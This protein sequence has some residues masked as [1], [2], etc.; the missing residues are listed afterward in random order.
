MEYLDKLKSR[1]EWQ[2]FL[3]AALVMT[4]NRFFDL[5]LTEA[6]IYAMFGGAGSYAVS[7]GLAKGPDDVA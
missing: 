1:T 5:G 4:L 2:A 3:M 7:R 6:D